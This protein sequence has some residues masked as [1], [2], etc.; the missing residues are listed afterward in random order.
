MKDIEIKEQAVKYI[1]G[2]FADWGKDIF[3]DY[4]IDDLNIYGTS[5]PLNGYTYFV[6]IDYFDRQNR[7]DV[8][9]DL[10][11]NVGIKV[12][13]ISLT[14]VEHEDELLD[15]NRKDVDVFCTKAMANGR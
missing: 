14:E 5:V 11:Y 9:Q 12:K 15:I 7:K 3:S 1:K 10:K 13:I 8:Y 2:Y 4:G 6:E